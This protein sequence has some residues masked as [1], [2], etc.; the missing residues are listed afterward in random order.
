MPNVND[1][2]SKIWSLMCYPFLTVLELSIFDCVRAYW[3]CHVKE[4]DKWKTAYATNN[5]RHE[6]DIANSERTCVTPI[7]TVGLSQP[8]HGFVE[9]YVDNIA[10][11]TDN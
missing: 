7:N 3:T 4:S 1:V 6:I 2:L 9:P 8:I 10:V 11:H 5:A